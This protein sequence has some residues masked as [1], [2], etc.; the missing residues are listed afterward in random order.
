[1]LL[2]GNTDVVSRT[3]WCLTDEPCCFRDSR[4]QRLCLCSNTIPKHHIGA[5]KSI[6]RF[7]DINTSQ[8]KDLTGTSGRCE[9]SKID[10]RS[11]VVESTT[12]TV[13][14]RSCCQQQ[15]ILLL[16]LLSTFVK[17]MI[18]PGILFTLHLY[19]NGT[20]LLRIKKVPPWKSLVM[21]PHSF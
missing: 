4:W 12:S 10:Q 13:L 3:F 19:W 16:L 8:G 14:F 6:A 20:S 7:S 1:M 21:A 2:T 15:I 5:K 9:E 17:Y 18:T 11:I